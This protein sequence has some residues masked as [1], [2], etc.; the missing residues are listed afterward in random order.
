M[1][2]EID[3]FAE[4]ESFLPTRQVNNIRKLL[5]PDSRLSP[6][7]KVRA[8]KAFDG[9]DKDLKHEGVGEIKL[10]KGEKR[11]AADGQPRLPEE[12][13]DQPPRLFRRDHRPRPGEDQE[14]TPQRTKLTAPPQHHK[15]ELSSHNRVNGPAGAKNSSW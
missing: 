1:A 4:L 7:K 15:R 2:Y 6:G 3:P 8:G 12:V 11:D 13:A 5:G 14:S 10:A 9:I